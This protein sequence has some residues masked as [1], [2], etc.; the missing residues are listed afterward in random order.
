MQYKNT[1]SGIHHLLKNLEC[2]LR[3]VRKVY[4][5]LDIF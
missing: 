2:G 5:V 4:G 3:F 1:K